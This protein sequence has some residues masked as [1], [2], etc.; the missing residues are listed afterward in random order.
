LNDTDPER[1]C[2]A[3]VYFA[4]PPPR[5]PSFIC[6]Q[7]ASRCLATLDL[8]L[9][10]RPVHLLPTWLHNKLPSELRSTFSFSN[11]FAENLAL[12]FFQWTLFAVVVLFAAT[13]LQALVVFLR[14]PTGALPPRLSAL[15]VPTSWDRVQDGAFKMLSFAA[16]ITTLTNVSLT[17]V[18]AKTSEGMVNATLALACVVGTLGII[19]IAA[20]CRRALLSEAALVEGKCIVVKGFMPILDALLIVGF[21]VLCGFIAF[22][23]LLAE[24]DPTLFMGAL[25]GFLGAA[26]TVYGL[27][28]DLAVLS[29]IFLFLVIFRLVG[30]RRCWGSGRPLGALKPSTNTFLDVFEPPGAAQTP[31]TDDFQKTTKSENINMELSTAKRSTASASSA[32]APSPSRSWRMRHEASR[33]PPP[34]RSTL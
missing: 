3:F 5:G 10:C 27:Y 29:S 22:T 31:K 21:V 25:S 28:Q 24:A 8:Q 4:R 19:C 30:N 18:F 2:G 26:K 7:S 1:G 13:C 16:G 12:E 17:A 32:S 11:E 14:L 9:R 23:T 33:W 20:S 34:T 6:Q 15:R